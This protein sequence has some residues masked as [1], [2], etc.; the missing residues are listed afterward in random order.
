MKAARRQKQ[1]GRAALVEVDA[2]GPTSPSPPAA[3]PEAGPAAAAEAASA[4]AGQAG[5]RAAVPDTP[6]AFLFPG[7][8]SQAVGMLKVG[9]FGTCLP[10]QALRCCVMALQR[11]R[12]H[13]EM[14]RVW[15][16]QA[17]ETIALLAQLQH[18]GWTAVA[19]SGY[20]LA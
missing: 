10:A 16:S 4:P 12:L 2:G 7:Q 13:I 8:G 11:R 18:Q 17:G 3:A 14:T 9:P 5:A 15:H 6:I 20:L 1:Q 19:W